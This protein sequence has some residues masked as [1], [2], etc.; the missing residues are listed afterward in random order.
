MT[1][2]EQVYQLADK[3]EIE[4]AVTACHEFLQSVEKTNGNAMEILLKAQECK[5]EE[6]RQQCYDI[7][8]QY[9]TDELENHELFAELEVE[10]KQGVLSHR[11]KRLE[12][13]LTKIY[14]Q[15]WGLIN[16]SL[17]LLSN[18]E[19][20]KKEMPHECARHMRQDSSFGQN[21][22]SE[23]LIKCLPCK[24]RITIMVQPAARS[25]VSQRMQSRYFSTNCRNMF[26]S[27]K[28]VEA[29][30]EIPILLNFQK[31]KRR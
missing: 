18:P 22:S 2:V 10:N 1:N 14:P 16:Y 7:L 24:T 5:A 6:A 9:T 26:L 29:L 13:C 21:Y 20:I 17:Y 19:K 3:Y 8:Q 27:Q 4:G 23:E 30:E 11:A 28:I 12:Q 25:Y 15:I 31:H